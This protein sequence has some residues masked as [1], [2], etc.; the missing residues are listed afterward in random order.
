VRHGMTV[1]ELAR[2]FNTE[3]AIGAKLTV[4]PLEGWMRGDWFDS[5]GGIWI[6]PSPNLRS[7][8]EAVLYPGV[9]MIE[10][11]NISVGRGTD[12]PFELVGAPWIDPAGLAKYLNER[13][14]SG[15]RFVPVRFTPNAS[16]YPNQECGGVNIVVTDRESLDA[17]EMGLEIAA[18]LRHLYPEQF[19]VGEIDGL[20]RNRATLDALM[21][22]EDPQRIAEDWQDAISKFD[23]LRAKY[24]LY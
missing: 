4:I 24:L 15:V 9:G 19:K 14:I 6:D 1:G 11:S 2:M 13:Q 12:T 20:V 10:G 5:T 8:T 16:V 22:G 23:L 3:R 7:L 21:K 17:P 18:A